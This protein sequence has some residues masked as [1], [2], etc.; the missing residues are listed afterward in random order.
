[1]DCIFI[2]RKYLYIYEFSFSVQYKLES[3][4]CFFHVLASDEKIG[5]TSKTMRNYGTGHLPLWLLGVELFIV[6]PISP[7]LCMT[8]GLSQD[9]VS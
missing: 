8:F 7:K 6:S 5:R 9:M 3:L 4:P 2:F 1:M